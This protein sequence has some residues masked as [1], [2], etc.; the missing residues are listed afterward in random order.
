MSNTYTRRN[1]PYQRG[2]LP[3]TT[4]RVNSGSKATVSKD[5]NWHYRRFHSYFPNG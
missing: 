3:Q 2:A 5:T 1:I 4:A